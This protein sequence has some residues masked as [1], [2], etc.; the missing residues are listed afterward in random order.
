MKHL[1]LAAAFL[2]GVALFPAPEIVEPAIPSADH[3]FRLVRLTDSISHPWAFDFL[4]SGDILITQRSGRLWKIDSYSGDRTEISGVP[5]VYARGQ[6]GLLDVRLAPDYERNGWIYFSHAVSTSTGPATAVS[7]AR[8]DGNRLVGLQRI[9]TANKGG[10]TS[11]HFG[12]RLAFD[13]QG[14]LYV[15]LGERGEGSRAQD[16]RD[17]AGSVLR[18]YPDG[19]VPD[20][21]P[22]VGDSSGAD[23]VFTYGHRNP[24]GMVFDPVTGHI[25][26]H[27]HGAKGGDEVNILSPGANYGWPVI[28][29]GTDYDGSKIGTGTAA[30]GMK[31]P[32]I[33]WDPSIAPSGMAVYTG[34]LFPDWQGDLFVGALA[35]QHLRRLERDSDGTIVSQE[36]LLKN[37]IGRIRDVRQGLD[38]ALYLLTDEAKGALFR[39]DPVRG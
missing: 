34:K 19:S 9:F 5:D 39:L 30:P 29:Y 27:E 18:L 28:T 7:R 1:F 24:Q 4:P 12:S 35:G 31:Q 21:N 20:D 6:G 36:V 32:E 14:H 8:L 10:R 22:F 3:V 17:H 33:Y 23:E 15:T 13:P 37:R 11:H 26:I 2:S 25:L 16:P 38:G